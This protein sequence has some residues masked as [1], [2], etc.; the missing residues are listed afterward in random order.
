MR[1]TSL[2]SVE[3]IGSQLPRIEHYPLYATTA[4]DDA[5]DIAAIA[6]LKLDAWQEH[7]LRGSLGERPDGRWS[8][9]RTCLVVPRQ[10]GKNAVLEARELAGLFLFGEQ[11]IIHTAHEFSTARESMLSLITRIRGSELVEQVAGFDM[12]AFEEDEDAR[13]SGLKTGNTAPSITLKPRRGQRSGNR[14]VYKA[15]SKGGGRGFT[16]DLVVFDEAYALNLE[17]MAALLPT[18]AARSKLGNPQLWFTSSAGMQGSTFLASLRKQGM[19][20]TGERLAYFEWS[21]D[22]SRA[23]DDVDGWYEANPGL[24]VRISEEYVRDEYDSLAA[25]TG[26]E[27]QFRRERLG[28]WDDS[29]DGSG[30]IDATKWSDRKGPLVA[31]TGSVVLGVD[32]SLD[33]QL[34]ALVAVG[35]GDDRV[36]QARLVK[37]AAGTG[38][39]PGLVARVCADH[40][41]VSTIVVDDRGS[42]A[43]LIPAIED[44]L[45]KEHLSVRVV[46]T[47]YPDLAEAC[48]ITFDLI[49]EGEMRH[50]GDA[51]LDAAVHGAEKRESEGAFVWSR[52][53]GGAAV[54]PLIAMSLALWEWQQSDYDVLDSIL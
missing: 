44:A 24:G 52:R 25:E 41:E 5:V 1:L 9:F 32:T 46:T 15:R 30:V 47:S 14:L 49:H 39:L 35:A 11:L 19:S 8:A 48:A 2:L 42:S 40:P 54:V 12:G 20:K 18:M 22:P 21:T 33:R 37:C 6:G 53:K 16:G 3:R 34:T 28:I 13:L 29:V 26:S 17:Q 27:E 10:N 31:P 38:W 7:V 43:P 45:E 50:A 23:S 51:E 4:A 36:P